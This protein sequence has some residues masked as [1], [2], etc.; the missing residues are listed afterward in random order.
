MEIGGAGVRGHGEQVDRLAR[1]IEEWLDGIVSEEGV[2][3]DRIDVPAVEISLGVVF[4]RLADVAALRIEDHR[5]FPGDDGE[6]FL[7]H[8]DALD[9][10]R[11][12]VGHV[13]LERGG[14]FRRLFDYSGEEFLRIARAV[15]AGP[16]V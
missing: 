5:D 16:R 14:E 10:H 1:V 4:L 8:A 12:E 3:R 6:D 15:L 7:K 11:L 2:E 13:R 9:A